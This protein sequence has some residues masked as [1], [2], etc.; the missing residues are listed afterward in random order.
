M[1]KRSYLLPFTCALLGGALV[2]VVIA[3]FGGLGSSHSTVTTVESAAPAAERANA[4][5]VTHS[6]TPHE[7]YVRDA[8]GVA[9]ITSTIVQ[10]SE[11]PFL[12]G[13]AQRQGQASGSG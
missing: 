6:F 11:S 9:F 13:E 10:K 7:V 12:F 2:A 8:P 3:P 4:A 5:Q 1:Q